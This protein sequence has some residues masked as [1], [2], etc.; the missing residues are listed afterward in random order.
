M[1]RTYHHAARRATV[2]RVEMME[3]RQLMTST[4]YLVFDGPAGR[5]QQAQIQ[6]FAFTRIGSTVGFVAEIETGTAAYRTLFA[7]AKS[8]RAVGVVDVDLPKG[9]AGPNALEY[10]FTGVKIANVTSINPA[11]AEFT[12]GFTGYEVDYHPTT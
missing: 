4:P 7:D 2:A 11:F 10:E 1:N 6:D 9:V 8:G 12:F 3:G 5:P